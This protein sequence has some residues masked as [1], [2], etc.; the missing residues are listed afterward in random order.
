MKPRT[1]MTLLCCCDMSSADIAKFTGYS[2]EEVRENMGAAQNFVLE[3]LQKYQ[4]QGTEFYPITSL[5]DAL[6]SG[7]RQ[8]ED[9]NVF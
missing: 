5:T 3:Q 9:E 7:M 6:Q 4:E 1:C 2:V 8:E